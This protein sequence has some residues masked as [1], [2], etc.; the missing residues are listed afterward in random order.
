MTW[1][2]R[3]VNRCGELAIFEVY[4]NDSGEVVGF[5]G[6]P[7]YPAGETLDE[8]VLNMNMYQE[9]ILKPVVDFWD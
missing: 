1:E 8:L 2:Y 9:A 4:Y 3:V 7:T 6:D 5:S